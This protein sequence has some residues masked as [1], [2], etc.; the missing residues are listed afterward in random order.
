MENLAECKL[1]GDN[2]LILGKV[3]SEQELELLKKNSNIV[4]FEKNELIFRQG[5]RTQHIMILLSGL[6]KIY[7]AGSYD[8]VL[9]LT[10][11]NSGN[12]AGILSLMSDEKV[13]H[14]SASTLAETEMLYVDIETF[15]KI[16]YSNPEF[17]KQV[18][19]YICKFSI[20]TLE[21]LSNIYYKQ[22]PGRIADVLLYFSE[23]IFQNNEFDFPLKRKELAQ[24]AGTSKESFIRTLNE[25]KNDK[26][27]DMQGRKVKINS[28]N[29]VKKLSEIG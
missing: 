2:N 28:I 4:R 23:Q 9:I 5:A 15:R 16:L 10:L 8:R 12:F 3:L 6:I 14:F 22:L 17:S 29:L 21:R 19:H 25:F 27:I 26:I 13:F 18:N 20:L 24:L 11:L 1:F 7:K